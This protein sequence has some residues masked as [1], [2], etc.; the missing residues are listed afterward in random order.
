[1]KTAGTPVTIRQLMDADWRLWKDIRLEALQNAPESFGSSLEEESR[2]TDADFQ[3]VLKSSYVL[4]VF[5]DSALV[6][7]AGFYALDSLKTRHRGV[8]WGMY[9]RPG[10]REKGMAH[11]LMSALIQHAERC[12]TQLHLTCVTCNHAAVSLYQK[13]GFRIY[14]TEPKALKMNGSF[15]DEYLMV[16]DLREEACG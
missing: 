8:L 12:V 13:Q 6:S 9:T 7:V 2:W 11:A 1:M 5:T 10:Q 14:G 4:G 16:L 3:R 15:F